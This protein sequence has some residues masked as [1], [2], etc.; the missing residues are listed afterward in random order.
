[1]TTLQQPERL[2]MGVYVCACV[3]VRVSALECVYVYVCVCIYV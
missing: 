3:Y 1:V 2:Q